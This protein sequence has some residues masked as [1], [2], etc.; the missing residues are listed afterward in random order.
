M[1]LW[2][3]TPVR[4]ALL[5][6]LVVA[7]LTLTSLGAAYLKMRSDTARAIHNDLRQELAA[8][9]VS[10]TPGAL[11]T[12]VAARARVTD[13][14]ETVY[15][16]L[17]NDGRYA[18]NARAVLTGGQV[19]LSALDASRP[20]GDA[21]YLHE[22]ERLSGGVLIV[23]ESLAPIARLTDTFL[24]LLA[25][26]LGPT[27]L[28]SLGL[29]VLIARRSARRVARIEATLDDIAG[30][31]LAARYDTCDRSGDDISR[32]GQGINRMAGKQQT[33]TE[34][35]R[36]VTTDIAHDLR[37]PLQRLSVL[38]D[39]LRSHLPA[40][41]PA[42]DLANSARG[43]TERATDVFRALLHIAQIEGG[44]PASRFGPVDLVA[45]ARQIAELYAPTADERGDQ[46][47]LDLPDLPVMITG[48]AGLL[49]QALANLVENALRHAPA[50]GTLTIS[51]TSD[52]PAADLTVGDTGPGIPEAER[53]NVLR[54][55]YRLERSRTTSGNGLGLALVSAI[56]SLHEAELSL[57][58]NH[59]GLRVTLRFPRRA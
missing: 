8:F 3:S 10:A 1:R 54:R 23:A 22:I 7:L 33:A 45:T 6:V 51:V 52:G 31:N 48:D 36:Q 13:P 32:I 30:G 9:D 46:L 28:V 29:G 4:Q 12:L 47:V 5:L 39:D 40:D 37:T 21:G 34:A 59:P 2:R 11:A 58:D 43:E 26:S 16:F 55:L 25:F 41:G 53:A 56:A 15:A 19:R 27:I 49:G 38:L 18:G 35:L 20:L 14:A 42:S 17:G 57:A 24:S 44:E 50:G